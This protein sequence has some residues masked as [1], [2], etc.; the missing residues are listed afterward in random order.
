MGS[1]NI[2]HL[3]MGSFN[4]HPTKGPTDLYPRLTRASQKGTKSVFSQA[5]A[6]KHKR[7]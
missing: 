4:P 7:F 5:F 2:F 1:V 3:K 6:S